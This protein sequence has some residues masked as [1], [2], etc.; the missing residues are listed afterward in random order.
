MKSP[1]ELAAQAEKS[2]MLFE[3]I[4]SKIQK[5]MD[6]SAI[7]NIE[8]TNLTRLLRDVLVL[9]SDCKCVKN[10][11]ALTCEENNSSVSLCN[12]C[13]LKVDV[14]KAIEANEQIE[15]MNKLCDRLKKGEFK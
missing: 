13:R 3:D 14:S 4:S 12:V 10:E 11:W 1:T 2:T 6:E 8:R 7:A 15:G 9:V 5:V